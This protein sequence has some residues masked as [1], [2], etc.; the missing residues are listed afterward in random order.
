MKPAGQPGG[1]IELTDSLDS[2]GSQTAFEDTITSHLPKAFYQ[3]RDV[4]P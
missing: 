1:W 4:T 3:V 2:A